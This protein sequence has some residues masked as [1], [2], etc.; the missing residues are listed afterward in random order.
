MLIVAVAACVPF[1]DG[2]V[3]MCAG[4]SGT[5]STTVVAEVIEPGT[6]LQGQHMRSAAGSTTTTILNANRSSI[7]SMG[8]SGI[9]VDAEY[10]DRPS[11]QDFKWAQVGGGWC[12]KGS[13]WLLVLVFVLGGV[14]CW[15]LPRP[16]GPRSP[17]QFHICV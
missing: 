9:V 12:A 4:R 10:V 14:V 3:Y 6:H 15:R 2:M 8:G 17:L 1:C 11:D 16:R 13:G 5:S 7:A